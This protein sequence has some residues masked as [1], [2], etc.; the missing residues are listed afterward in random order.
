MIDVY[1]LEQ[2][3]SDVPPDTAWLTGREAAC[4]DALRFVK[5]RSQWRLG[6]W[7]AKRAVEACLQS[8]V[9]GHDFS[10]VEIRAAA[11][12]A[13]EVLCSG[14]PSPATISISHSSGIAGCAV[15]LVEAELG[16]DIETIEPHSELF[17]ADYFCREEQ[18]L[19]RSAAAEDRAWLV[20]LLWSAK[21]SALKA[22]HQGLRLDTR[23]V[24]VTEIDGMHSAHHDR[25]NSL[26]VRGPE[27]KDFTG[28]WRSAG[29]FV[30][31]V[32]A[33]PPPG[34]PTDIVA[35]LCEPAMA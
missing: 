14:R 7:T 15:A 9:G 11:S 17:I 26:R 1:W 4:M 35:M 3:D 34:I 13:P 24:M 12:G 21:E 5:R 25:W 18:C 19:I 29:G 8:I 10:P 16:C 2:S 27:G 28:W 22:L 31:T 32:V 20:T 33:D 30:R 23:S 6:R